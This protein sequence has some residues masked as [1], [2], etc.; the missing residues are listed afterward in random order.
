MMIVSHVFRTCRTRTS[1]LKAVNLGEIPR[2]M[3]P[4]L[5]VVNLPST[6]RDESKALKDG[7][8]LDARVGAFRSCAKVRSKGKSLVRFA[9]VCHV[10]RVPCISDGHVIS[11]IIQGSQGPTYCFDA[12]AHERQCTPARP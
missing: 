3:R 6:D 7:P 10:G 9:S 12:L 8:V 5:E 1:A 2:K 4:Y 11:V